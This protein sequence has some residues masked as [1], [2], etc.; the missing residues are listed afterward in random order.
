MPGPRHDFARYL[1]LLVGIPAAVGPDL[2]AAPVLKAA[3]SGA[4]EATG[5]SGGAIQILERTEG[6]LYHVMAVGADGPALIGL[7][8]QT[9]GEG[10]CGR[11]ADGR[12]ATHLDRL[13]SGLTELNPVRRSG[14]KVLSLIPIRATGEVMGLIL[15]TGSRKPLEGSERAFLDAAATQLGTALEN[16]G[17]LTEVMATGREWE[18]TFNAIEDLILTADSEGRVTRVNQALAE[19]LGEDR[20]RLVGRPCTELA[21]GGLCGCDR[22]GC[23]LAAVLATQRPM[24]VE[25]EVPVLKG[26][27][28]ITVSPVGRSGTVTVAHDIGP[29]RELERARAEADR[30]AEMNRFKSKIVAEVSHNFRTPLHGIISTAGMM[31]DGLFGELEPDSGEAVED[32][33]ISGR[34]LE[35]LVND[36]VDLTKIEAGKLLLDKSPVSLSQIVEQ[37][38][39]TTAGRAAERRV[40]VIGP[41]AP[42]KGLIEADAARLKQLLKGLL[43][44]AVD[45]TPAGGEVRLDL[46]E[47]PQ[48]L[49]LMMIDQGSDEHD[50]GHSLGLTLA[51]RLVDLHGGRMTVGDGPQG[52][53]SLVRVSLPRPTGS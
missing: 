32:I 47:S 20:E 37:V 53:E 43:R 23:R 8:N 4:V 17:L 41:E 6:R 35:G 25:E 26:R 10:L 28:L 34:R 12:P 30:L 46:A 29:L 14:L 3:L 15:V 9:L 2:E 27:Y 11:A 36:L 5:S 33:L 7:G 42:P 39:E 40:Q 49:D 16:I 19:I 31:K 51:N 44:R 45:R 38:I 18:A 22:S 1:D 13:P 48:R 24:T 21:D 52:R 50:D